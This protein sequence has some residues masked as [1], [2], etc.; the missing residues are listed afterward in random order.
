MK[1]LN[2]DN[3]VDLAEKAI[4][5]LDNEKNDRGRPIR[6]VTTSQIRNLLAMTAD[7]YNEVML[8]R[9]EQLDEE[10]KGK[11]SYLRVRCLYEA[12]RDESVKAFVQNSSLLE[13]LPTIVTKKDYILFN[14][15]MESL[16]AWHKYCHGKD[17]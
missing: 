7:I 17:S 13:I 2:N 11:I 5:S 14:H 4:K 1:L 6:V 16:I 12:G 9:Q 15:Y 3:Y 8:L 10:L